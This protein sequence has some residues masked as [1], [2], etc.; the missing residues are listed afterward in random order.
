[1]FRAVRL[2]RPSTAI[3]AFGATDASGAKP[4]PCRGVDCNVAG[5]V[6][7]ILIAESDVLRPFFHVAAAHERSRRA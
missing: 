7:L 1:M 3:T 6:G 2:N 4:N 5:G